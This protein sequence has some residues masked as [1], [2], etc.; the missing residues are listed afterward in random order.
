MMLRQQKQKTRNRGQGHFRLSSKGI[1][2]IKKTCKR[3]LQMASV[4]GKDETQK[5]TY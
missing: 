3:T 1:F 4:I 2:G 5:C